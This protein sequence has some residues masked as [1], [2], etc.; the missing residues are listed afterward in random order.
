M[1][2][3]TRRLLVLFLGLFFT[4]AWFYQ[5]GGW[6]QNSRLD[7]VLA[8]IHQG[9]VRIDT[10][11]SNT[12]DAAQIN[13]HFYSDKAP[14]AALTAVPAAWFAALAFP[15]P[16][17]ISYVSTL[18]SAALPTALAAVLIWLLAVRLGADE[19]GALF[20]A[21]AFGLATPAWIYATLFFG[22]A[23]AAGCLTAAAAC[24]LGLS[25]A[26]SHRWLGVGLGASAGWAIASEFPAAPA[27]FA[28]MALGIFLTAPESRPR[29]TRAV[30]LGLAA[31]LVPL[32]AY[33]I[34]AF[35]T[36]FDL[37]YA[38][39]P[40]FPG[41]REGI[42]GVSWPRPGVLLEILFLPY[43]GL[44]VASPLLL[45]AP[46]GMWLGLRQGPTRAF[47]AAA[48]AVVVIFLLINCGYAYWWGGWAYG[49]RHLVPILPFLCL[50][51]AL[52]YTRASRAG[53]GVLLGLLAL[54]VFLTLVAV[55]TAP[56]VPDAT[57]AM[58]RARPQAY[59][60]MRTPLRSFLLPSFLH[61]Y[62]ALNPQSVIEK[63]I[64]PDRNRR[65]AW[66]LGQ[67]M[68]LSG[69][70][71][72]LP[73]LGIWV[74]G[75]LAWRGWPAFSWK[76]TEVVEPARVGVLWYAATVLMAFG[77]AHTRMMGSDFWWH[78]A[79]G[80]WILAHTTIPTADPW[81]YTTAGNAWLQHEW[82]T[83]VIYAGWER[84]F[85]LEA[86][87]FWKWLMVVGTFTLLLR[88]VRRQGASWP[89]AFLAV[90][91]SAATA[92]PFF[93]LRPHLGSLLCYAILLNVALPPARPP[94]WLPAFFVLWA[95]L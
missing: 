72:L 40:N 83:D 1:T 11:V 16:V 89:A 70:A 91:L 43:R 23:L 46:L 75:V 24:A 94:L 77:F 76:S 52:L 67:K 35:G 25:D 12:G 20:G 87:I 22:H 8:L 33:N 27:A 42:L 5:G 14:G 32:A 17:T 63:T 45:A 59:E 90:T 10:F 60:Q 62:L 74:L 64:P 53:R 85:G 71:S 92:A 19:H 31:G 86:C 95:N 18:A 56:M 47:W 69:L 13:G 30:G 38:H 51:L 4:Y 66:N 82:L 2:L 9:T 65:A 48:A 44:F 36:P 3:V 39:Q 88:V 37:G 15:D 73:L 29:A 6:N 68:G 26:K 7:L 49:P 55:S 41:L 80:R 57:E 84:A 34:A 61:G 81:S 54:S 21:L 79:T 93:D 78:L 58:R 28:L 50:G